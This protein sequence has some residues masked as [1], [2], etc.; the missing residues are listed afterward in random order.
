MSPQAEVIAGSVA[1]IDAGHREQR[2]PVSGAG[3]HAV[4]EQARAHSGKQMSD[5]EAIIG[6]L[7][8]QYLR[9]PTSQSG[10]FRCW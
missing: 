10:I 6:E 5:A 4:A 1:R 3:M 8:S 9:C 2:P 7:V